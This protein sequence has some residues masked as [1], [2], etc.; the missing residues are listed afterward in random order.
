MSKLPR[1]VRGKAATGQMSNSFPIRSD[2]LYVKVFAT[3]QRPMTE[4]KEAEVPAYPRKDDRYHYGNTGVELLYKGVP[5]F[6]AVQKHKMPLRI[7][8]H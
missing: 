5:L 4:R 7:R 1:G 6:Q 2:K 8:H 3:D